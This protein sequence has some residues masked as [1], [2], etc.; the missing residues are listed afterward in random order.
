MA[1]S[2]SSTLVDFIVPVPSSRRM[3]LL[4]DGML[5]I[6]FSAI[7]A[8]TSFLEIRLPFTPVPIT[9]QTLFVLLTGAALGSKRGALA[10]LAYLV[11]GAAGLPVFAGGG[12]GIAVL[13]GPT[14]GYLWSFPVVAF[15]V[16]WLCE[17]GLDR[18]F[19]TSAFAMLP[20]TAI[21]YLMGVSWLAIVMHISFSSAIILGMLPF[22]PGDLFKL[23]VAALLLPSAWAVVRAWHSERP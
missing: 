8:A 23:V 17:R 18:S 5:I 6:G 3:H 9:L 15:V 14:G 13:L 4:R 10:M 20:G 11:E 16:G 19:L 2:P 21:N 1:I 12:H 7:I 22:I